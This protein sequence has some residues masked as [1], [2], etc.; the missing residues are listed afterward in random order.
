MEHF[1]SI[2]AL[3]VE[4]LVDPVTHGRALEPVLRYRDKESK[5]VKDKEKLIKAFKNIMS[6]IAGEVNGI[7]MP[8]NAAGKEFLRKFIPLGNRVLFHGPAAALTKE[9]QT[10]LESGSDHLGRSFEG[11]R[12]MMTRRGQSHVLD[13]AIQYCLNYLVPSEYQHTEIPATSEYYLKMH[14]MHKMQHR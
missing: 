13:C 10:W 1:Y 14:K 5:T 6:R 7:D 2:F 9:F 12:A 11:G 8:L 4:K 3:L